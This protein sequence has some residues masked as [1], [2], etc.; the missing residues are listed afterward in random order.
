MIFVVLCDFG[1]A[2]DVFVG[3]G[4]VPLLPSRGGALGRHPTQH[5]KRI[6]SHQ[7]GLTHLVTPLRGLRIT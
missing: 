5:P 7:Y 6:T 4:A 2:N 3:P 1:I